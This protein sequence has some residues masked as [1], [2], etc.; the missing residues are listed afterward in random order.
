[1]IKS[2][3]F[4]FIDLTGITVSDLTKSHTLSVNS[5]PASTTNSNTSSPR[6]NSN[7]LNNIP[8][9]NINNIGNSN[10]IKDLDN[11]EEMMQKTF[12]A[13]TTV[14]DQLSENSRQKVK[15]L[16]SFIK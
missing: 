8:K 3:Y 12:T 11:G 6:R 14:I 1:M 15:F 5:S 10:V 7:T 13:L 9:I 16:F 2:S 4:N